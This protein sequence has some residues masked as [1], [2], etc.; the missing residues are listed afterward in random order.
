MS[1]DFDRYHIMELDWKENFGCAW[2]SL[3]PHMFELL[4]AKTEES[5]DTA[6][7]EVRKRVRSTHL[8]KYIVQYAH[9]SRTHAVDCYFHLILSNLS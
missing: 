2:P 3:S 4:Y 8:Q 6:L 9:S 5:N 1:S 7:N